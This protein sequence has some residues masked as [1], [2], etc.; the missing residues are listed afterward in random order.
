LIATT[1]PNDYS[2]Y[3]IDLL[4]DGLDFILRHL[5]GPIWSRTI[6]TYTTEGKQIL[7]YSREEALARFKKANLLDCR[8]NAYPD[9]TGFGSINRQASPELHFHRFGFV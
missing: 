7:V 3:N 6:S 8:I 2:S 1:N 5:E 4:G 9:Y